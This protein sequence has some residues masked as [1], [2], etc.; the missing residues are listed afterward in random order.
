MISP[1]LTVLLLV[2]AWHG[3]APKLWFRELN[4]ATKHPQLKNWWS[5]P[6]PWSCWSPSSFWWS[7]SFATSELQPHSS[8]TP[9]WS[10]GM[11]LFF[12]GVESYQ[13]R[14]YSLLSLFFNLHLNSSLLPS[15]APSRNTHKA[16]LMPKS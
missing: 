10:F 5:S 16:I 7:T 6:I 13:T 9:Q 3:S 15:F 14:S 11:E 8:E 2:C 12:C 4:G 1:I